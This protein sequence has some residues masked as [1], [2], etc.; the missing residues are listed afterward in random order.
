VRKL[1]LVV[2]ALFLASPA[3]AQQAEV[4]I[5]SPIARGAIAKYKLDSLTF[6]RNPPSARFALVR[7]DSSNGDIDVFDVLVTQTGTSGCPST[8]TSAPTVAGM[9]TAI[10]N[11]AP[12]ET[13]ID[14]RRV[15]YRL[16]RYLSTTTGCIQGVTLVP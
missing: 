1:L 4:T 9:M 13:G 16:M 3:L 7:Q 15:N 12:G 5:N 2:A 6:E 11:A 10:A 14:S 8:P